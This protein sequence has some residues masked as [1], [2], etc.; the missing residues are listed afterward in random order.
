MQVDWT[1]S[2]SFKD[3][4]FFR[5][6]PK[7]WKTWQKQHSLHFKFLLILSFSVEKTTRE[8]KNRTKS[9]TGMWL[10]KSLTAWTYWIAK[11]HCIYQRVKA[12]VGCHH[13]VCFY[14]VGVLSCNSFLRHAHSKILLKNR[15]DFLFSCRL[16]FKCGNS[17]CI[18]DGISLWLTSKAPFQLF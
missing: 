6:Q 12:K 1:I 4:S 5:I 13:K 10:A 17:L 14:F 7:T 8:L 16:S 9:V 11:N 18:C 15:K 3:I 2:F